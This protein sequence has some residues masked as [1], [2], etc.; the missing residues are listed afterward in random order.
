MV[1]RL[2]R[3]GMEPLM[4]MELCDQYALSI[5]LKITF[6]IKCGLGIVDSIYEV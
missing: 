3:V 6:R 4:P 1:C 5:M 2:K